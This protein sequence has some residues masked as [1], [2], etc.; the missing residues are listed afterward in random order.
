MGVLLCFEWRLSHKHSWFTRFMCE[1]TCVYLLPNEWK[2][3]RLHELPAP[4]IRSSMPEEK[5]SAAHFCTTL[6]SAPQHSTLL[7]L[8]SRAPPVLHADPPRTFIPHCISAA[9]CSAE[10]SPTAMRYRSFLFVSPSPKRH[11]LWLE[12]IRRWIS[13][14]LQIQKKA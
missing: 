8:P 14:K 9:F 7:L 1:P 6:L 4:G 10:R 5:P 3:S 13:K 11:L 2:W 12:S